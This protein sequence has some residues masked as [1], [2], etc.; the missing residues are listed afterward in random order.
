MPTYRL[1][2]L[3]TGTD[4]ASTRLHGI[5]RALQRIFQIA[6]GILVAGTIRLLSQ[7]FFDLGRTAI[8][9]FSNL[10]RMEVSLQSLIARE[11]A[12]GET[13]EEV[14]SFIRN[15]TDA[16]ILQI[17]KLIV[18]YSALGEEMLD[19]KEE[20]EGLEEGDI[21]W[22]ANSVAIREN[23]IEMAA[24][25]NEIERMQGLQGKLVSVTTSS[26][27][28]TLS[29][30]DALGLAAKPAEELTDWI[31]RLSLRSPFSET[32]ILM[33]LRVAAG[34]GFITQ[35][36]SELLTEEERL[37]AAREDDVVTAQRL[38]VGLLDLMAAIGL[39]S[40]NL[41]RIVLAL[42]QVRAHGR[43][44]AQEIR[45]MVNAGVGLDVMAMAM[46]MTVEQFMNA[47]KA[48]EIL[49]EDFLPALVRL[50]EE[51]LA[52]AADRVMDTFGGALLSL[53]K[54]R[55]VGLRTFFGPLFESLTPGLKEL[56]ENLRSEENLDAIEE[57]GTAF[58]DQIWG[59]YN[60]LT[61]LVTEVRRYAGILKDEG[62]IEM[63]LTVAE[64]I[65]GEDKTEAVVAAADAAD[66]LG[67]D[68][69]FA[70]GGLE[71]AEGAFGS[72]ATLFVGSK[73][74]GFIA[75]WGP[76]LLGWV[77]ALGKRLSGLGIVVAILGAIWGGNWFGIRDKLKTAWEET[78]RPAL[79]K[80]WEWLQ[81]KIP[82]AL[83]TARKWWEDTFIPAL[84][85]GETWIKENILPTLE[86]WY[87]ALK[88]RV[89]KAFQIVTGYIEKEVLPKLN[90][91]WLKLRDDVIPELVILAQDTLANVQ[92][93]LIQ[94]AKDI[95][96]WLLPKLTA[97]QTY[98][99]EDA[100]PALTSFGEWLISSGKKMA[101]FS[102]NF[103]K[104]L[105]PKF[106]KMA[107]QWTWLTG[108]IGPMAHFNFH[109]KIFSS[110]RAEEWST[111]WNEHVQP[112]IDSIA[113]FWDEH[114]FPV[115]E[116]FG[117]LLK[118]LVELAFKLGGLALF[119]VIEALE[120][121]KDRLF[122]EVTPAVHG[123]W[124]KL[125]LVY[126]Y[127]I[128][129]FG[130][131][132]TWFTDD[133]LPAFSGAIDAVAGALDDLQAALRNMNIWLE[134]LDIPNPFAEDSP[135]PM[136]LAFMHVEDAIRSADAAAKES[137]FFDGDQVA[138]LNF[139][140]LGAGSGAWGG[141]PVIIEGDTNTFYVADG[142]TYRFIEHQI[143]ETRKRRFSEYMGKL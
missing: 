10:E 11:T 52:G 49:A 50:L 106:D 74:W 89:G 16:E 69:G 91:L 139:G 28:K 33:A 114:V 17:D 29:L 37:A 78:I 21:D 93:E 124:E 39:P 138:R 135:S 30:A 136:A 123:F 120:T 141:A 97:I 34:Y 38:T 73:L 26:L 126:D 58:R 63:G 68:M 127:L 83:E 43:L 9:S 51:D 142:D 109:L 88:D 65:F 48:G 84:R 36:A 60:D 25:G 27:V 103:G 46:G 92:K 61:F 32:D 75:K 71:A 107:E 86:E 41:G 3:V 70:A 85:E 133:V 99:E 4:R 113:E 122:D 143:E 44:L 104:Y 118:N 134:R 19:L 24:L 100:K 90:E 54:F 62:R 20:R 81:I 23:T 13:V 102:K 137:V 15:L 8:T 12:R 77:F 40:E 7:Q 125:N 72:L 96:K 31:V 80:M 53:Q 129:P 111:A 128:N 82:E 45:Q 47:Q 131:I 79:E 87:I 130:N 105:Q 98:W 55:E 76:R 56:A 67:T 6:S 1:D 57:W 42:G 110:K 59:I 22:L 112:I 95:E 140:K 5:R 101:T 117:R 119:G 94:T 14:S 35:Y 2:I 116:E 64:D 66:Q 115:L 108:P 121:L 132:I 18:Q